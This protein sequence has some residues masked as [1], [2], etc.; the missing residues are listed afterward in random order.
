MQVTLDL[1]MMF[2]ILESNGWQAITR[3]VVLMSLFKRR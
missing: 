2:L 3:H 1:D